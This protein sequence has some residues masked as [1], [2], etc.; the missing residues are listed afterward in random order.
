MSI[1]YQGTAEWSQGFQDFR[2]Q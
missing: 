2:G 1:I